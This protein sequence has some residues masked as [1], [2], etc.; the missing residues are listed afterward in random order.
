MAASLTSQIYTFTPVAYHL[1]RQCL[2][3]AQEVYLIVAAAIG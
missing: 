2:N 3:V 1:A